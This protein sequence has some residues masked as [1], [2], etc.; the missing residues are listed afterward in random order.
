MN[1]VENHKT[2]AHIIVDQGE[3]PRG[4]VVNKVLDSVEEFVRQNVDIGVDSI[5]L[6]VSIE[7]KKGVG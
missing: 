5:Q 3:L 1:R 4:D 7:Y 2:S 6:V